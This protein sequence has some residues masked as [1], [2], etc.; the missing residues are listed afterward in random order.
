MRS[1]NGTSHCCCKKSSSSIS[2]F[3][4]S[5]SSLALP[6][7]GF[8]FLLFY[9]QGAN[10]PRS[11]CN[12]GIKIT[13]KNKLCTL[14]WTRKN[15]CPARQLAIF[16]RLYPT[17]ELLSLLVIKRFNNSKMYPAVVSDRT[18]FC[19]LNQL[20]V[21]LFNVSCDTKFVRSTRCLILPNYW[22]NHQQRLKID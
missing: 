17:R 22:G 19:D 2:R 4:S 18:P 8:E 6:H 7:K 15:S 14:Y 9:V 5:T 13:L 20:S 16:E 11:L 12:C 3:L 1:P 21:Q 10:K